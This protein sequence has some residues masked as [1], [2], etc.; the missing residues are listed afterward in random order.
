MEFYYTMNRIYALNEKGDTI[1]EITFPPM[2]KDTVNIDHTFVDDSLRGQGVAGKLMLAAA[3]S[4]RRSGKKA[5]PTCSYAQAW[6]E[7][8]P[9]FADILKK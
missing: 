9:E 5:V 7:K 1:A 3:E 2:D 8:H 4:L 6:F